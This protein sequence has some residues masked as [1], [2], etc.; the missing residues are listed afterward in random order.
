MGV[1]CSLLP[2]TSG[3]QQE[4]ILA[5]LLFII[6]ISDLPLS[7]SE[8]SLL[9][10]ADD[11]KCLHTIST[12]FDRLLLQIE[13]DSLQ[14]WSSDWKLAFN[15]SKCEH[16]LFSVSP[17]EKRHTYRLRKHRSLI[18]L[19]T[20]D[21]GNNFS[22]NLSWSH[23]YSIIITK[24]YNTLYFCPI[25]FHHPILTKL[26]I[27]CHNLP[28]YCSQACCPHLLKDIKSLEQVQRHSTKFVLNNYHKDRLIS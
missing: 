12:P 9:M 19:I 8:S 17:E 15:P 13:L 10:F 21:L 14:S 23:H 6:C 25:F 5:P 20:R 16:T 28:I 7:V 11:C 27:S 26:S 3:I 24:T 4:I 2:V 18:Q 22:N 1:S